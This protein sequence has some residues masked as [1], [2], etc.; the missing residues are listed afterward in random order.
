MND[1]NNPYGCWWS[2]RHELLGLVL[3]FIATILTIITFNSFGIAAMFLVGMV[4]CGHRY[5]FC[6]SCAVCHPENNLHDDVEVL[7]E[8]SLTPPID[9]TIKKE[10]TVR[11][12][13][14]M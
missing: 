7:S 2:H 6:H 14:K 12:T 4:L 8:D 5:F 1:T 9:K 3:I 13:P 10:P 11:R